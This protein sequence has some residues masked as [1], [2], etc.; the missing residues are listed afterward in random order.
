MVIAAL[1]VI[2]K[3]CHKSCI[4]F[5][6]RILLFYGVLMMETE[7]ILG[8]QDKKLTSGWCDPFVLKVSVHCMCNVFFAL[9]VNQM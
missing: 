5:P 7:L 8:L 9:T 4:K 1:S 2:L 3:K 6:V